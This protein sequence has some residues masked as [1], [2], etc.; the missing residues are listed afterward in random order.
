[1]LPFTFPI[2]APNGKIV[3][4]ILETTIEQHSHN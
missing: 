3:L 4:E 2:I 1:M